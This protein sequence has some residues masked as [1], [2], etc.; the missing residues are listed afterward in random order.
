MRIR[1]PRDTL[2][3]ALARAQGFVSKTDVNPNTRCVRLTT[4]SGGKLKVEA[5]DT[6]NSLTANYAVEVEYDG[7]T[8]VEAGPLYEMA[9]ALPDGEVTLTLNER[10][11]RLELRPFGATKAMFNLNT[12]SPDDYPPTDMRAYKSRMTIEGRTLCRMIEEVAFSIAKDASRYGL[13]GAHVEVITPNSDEPKL[14]LVSTD[15]SRLSWSQAPVKGK[16]TMGRNALIP[17]RGLVELSKVV[18][19]QTWTIESDDSARALRFSADGVTIAIR[20]LDGEFPDYRQVVPDHT[21]QPVLAVIHRSDLSMSLRRVDTVAQ[22][23][24]NHGA[25]LTID[26][27]TLSLRS[28]NADRG[29]CDVDV[30]SEIKRFNRD[31]ALSTGVNLLF[32]R[33]MVAATGNASAYRWYMGQGA[34]DPMMLVPDDRDDALFIVM[35]MRM[36]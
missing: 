11:H 28:E 2:I 25:R 17:S 21:G 35:P 20:L 24:R 23:D 13:N 22:L 8:L 29:D 9:K 10:N 31:S 27:D 36:D 4:V 15:G 30:P 26:N 6:E 19:D 18:G 1:I 12:L 34:L 5:T 32:L 14:R 7:A 3:L 33:E 16:L